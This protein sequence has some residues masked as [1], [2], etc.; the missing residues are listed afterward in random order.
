MICLVDERISAK[1]ERR[2]RIEGFTVIKFPRSEKLSLPISSHPDM[3]TFYHNGNIISTAE[4]CESFPWVFSDICEWSQS[5]KFTFTA[6]S[7]SKEYPNDAIFNALVIGDKIFMRTDTVSESLIDYAVCAGLEII[8]CEQGYPA[9]TTLAFGN[10]A[11]TADLG[12]AKIL[13]NSGINVTE[14]RNGD[15]SLPPYEY[16]FIGGASG[17]FENKVYFLGSIEEHRDFEIIDKAIR[18]AGYIPVSLSD[19]PLV[20]LGRIVFIH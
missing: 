8:R 12:M 18:D 4:Y 14:I 3:L 20:D 6:D 11:I 5:V 16:G 19:E 9:C 7:F 17:V 10:S 13:K 2:L 1:C 15:I